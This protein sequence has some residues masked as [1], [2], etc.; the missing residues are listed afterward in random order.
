[1]SP[2]AASTLRTGSV[3]ED[4]FDEEPGLMPF[5]IIT[6]IVSVVLVAVELLRFAAE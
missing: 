5:A 6:V 4:D 2:P 1:M 3:I